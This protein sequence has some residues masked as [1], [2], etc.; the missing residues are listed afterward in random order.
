[1]LNL[2]RIW[3]LVS[4]GLVGAGWILS[5][6]QALTPAGYAVSFGLLLAGIL[7]IWRRA[8]WHWGHAPGQTWRIFRRRY[9]RTAPRLFLLLFCLAALGGAIYGPHSHND[10]S[11]YR[12]PR[13]LHWLGAHQWHWI[14]TYDIRMNIANCGYEWLTAPLMEF[15]HTDR[16]LFL[17][18]LFSFALLPGLLFQLFRRLGVGGKVAWWWMWVLPGAFCFALQA[19]SLANDGFAAVYAVASVVLALGTRTGGK[20]GDLWLSV[21]AMA[22][23]TGVK[24]TYIPLGLLWFIA[25]LPSFRLLTRRLGGTLGVTAVALLISALPMIF[26]NLRH[27]GNWIGIPHHPGPDWDLWRNMESKSPFWSVIGNIFSLS[28]QTFAPPI[29]PLSP[30][31]DGWMQHFVQIPWGSHFST[32]PHFCFVPTY[33]TEQSAGLGFMVGG[34]LLVSL[35]WVW[36]WQGEGRVAAAGWQVRALRWAPFGLLLLF[37]AKLQVH[38]GIRQLSPYYP[39]LVV[40]LLVRPGMGQLVRRAW[41]QRLA[42]LG[43]VVTA[44]VLVFIP[45]R[46]LFPANTLLKSLAARYPH[47]GGLIR[48]QSFYSPPEISR[49]SRTCFADTLPDGEAVVGYGTDSRAL[50]PGLWRPFHRRVERLRPEDS[51]AYL[52][53]LGIHYIAV[54]RFFCGLVNCTLD[55]L[56]VK[57]DARMVDRLV[58]Y[59]GLNKPP[60]YIYLIKLNPH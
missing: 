35:L 27:G 26:L 17:I 42:L 54:D 32:F 18:D 46:P 55:E 41:W 51:R 24:Q 5:A 21:L 50:E 12:T 13:V 38:E 22:L 34:L 7:V 30:K 10:A 43:L 15:S 23:L 14:H 57:Y 2:A 48:L 58:L 16:L 8:G 33:M 11:E 49:L 29:F 37:M 39:F 19:G 53:A 44:L 1:M 56:L 47:S 60:D 28:L 3:I 45:V 9:R 25:V 40:A 31:W 6:L 4:A 20:V 59:G 36:R 52:D